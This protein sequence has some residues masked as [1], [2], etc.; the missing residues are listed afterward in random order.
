MASEVVG[1]DSG[2]H[3]S[4]DSQR[5]NRQQAWWGVQGSVQRQE[6][7]QRSSGTG[8]FPLGTK[9]AVTEA[10][11]NEQKQTKRLSRDGRLHPELLGKSCI[12]SSPS[13]AAVRPTARKS[14]ESKAFARSINAEHTGVATPDSL[15]RDSIKTSP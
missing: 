14:L 15:P 5:S 7:A 2:R 11:K 13:V 3:L 4:N 8:S 9:R 1:I 6:A 10:R 12:D